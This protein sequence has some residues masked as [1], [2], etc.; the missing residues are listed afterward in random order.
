M[1]NDQLLVEE[2]KN[3]STEAFSELVRR[4]QKVV[5]RLAMRMTRDLSLAEDITQESFV[6]AYRK[7]HMFEHRSSFKSWLYQI[8]ANTAKNKLRSKKYEII[9]IDKINISVTPQ[10]EQELIKQNISES[11]K[12]EIDELPPKQ[13]MAL[14]LRV[15]EDMSFK[16]IASIMECPY[17]TAK[18]NYRHALMKLRHRF[19]EQMDV[20]ELEAVTELSY[21]NNNQFFAEVES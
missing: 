7:L 6:K 10:A 19:Q 21:K 18:A 14:V 13:R 5:L 11:F 8:A 15:F 20:Q 16:E 1:K 3:G 12:E 4:H 2:A 17:D 9:P